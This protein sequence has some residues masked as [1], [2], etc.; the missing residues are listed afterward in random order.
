[1]G[2]I[3]RFVGTIFTLLLVTRLLPG[4][5][6]ESFYTALIV[7]IVL[8]VL[9][10][11]IK[12]ILS[13]LTLPLNIITLGLFSFVINA[14]LLLL[15]ASFVEGFHIE[16]FLPALIGGAIIAVVGWILDRIT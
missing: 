1:M 3:V 14:V 7:A 8:G 10:V 5:T 4:F 2:L 11:T 13:I 9:N 12:P 16:G 6:V 15:I